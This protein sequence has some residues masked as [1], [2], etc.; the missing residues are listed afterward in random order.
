MS[1]QSCCNINVTKKEDGLVIDV[2]GIEC[3]EFFERMLA[4]CCNTQD[5]RKEGCC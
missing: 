2:T 4:R 5:E 1:D 3:K